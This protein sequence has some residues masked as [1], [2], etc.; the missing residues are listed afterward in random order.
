MDLPSRFPRLIG[1]VTLY[2]HVHSPIVDLYYCLASFIDLLNPL[3]ICLEFAWVSNIE[4]QCT[5]AF[6]HAYFYQIYTLEVASIKTIPDL[7]D[8]ERSNIRYEGRVA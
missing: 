2:S 7:M 8:I 1:L 3:G 4:S 5:G 6:R